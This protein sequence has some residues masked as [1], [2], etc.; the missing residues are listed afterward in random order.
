MQVYWWQF[1]CFS[2]G[3]CLV[4][5]PMHCS[6]EAT[7]FISNSRR[8]YDMIYLADTHSGKSNENMDR[9]CFCVVLRI[10][11]NSA[12]IKTRL[13]HLLSSVTP[14]RDL[15]PHFTPFAYLSPFT[16]APASFPYPTSPPIEGGL[17]R[18]L[19]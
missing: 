1:F 7:F 8:W 11:L 17:A 5:A 2:G 16:P 13:G 18:A 14:R 4:R 15:S 9:V 6:S 3:N 19:S 12:K 10:N